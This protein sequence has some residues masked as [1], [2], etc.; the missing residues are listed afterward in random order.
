[1]ERKYNAVLLDMDGTIADTYNVP[2][3]LDQLRN[4]SVKP[5]EM[6]EPLVSESTL[7]SLFTDENII[8]C[9]MLPKGVALGTPYADACQ[10]AKQQWL[11]RYFPSLTNVLFM[12]YSNDK[13]LGEY[14]KKC[15]LVDDSDVIR[16]NFNGYTLN[17]SALLEDN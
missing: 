1:M 3:W 8:I 9:T 12:E 7:L 13:S 11:E 5:F 14:S 17:A 4:E 16:N 2:D 15:L 6:A 10:R